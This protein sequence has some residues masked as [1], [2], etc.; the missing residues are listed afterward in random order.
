VILG[1]VVLILLGGAF[2]II[3]GS[4]NTSSP[5]PL[6]TPVGDSGIDE[7]VVMDEGSSSPS[8]AEDGAAEKTVKEFKVTGVPFSFTPNE[9]RVKK[10]DTVRVT[11]TNQEGM[12]DF[13]LDE[14]NV[15]TKT[16]SAGQSET[17][18]FVAN[19]TGKF[20]YYCSVGNHRQ[21]GM[22]GSLIVE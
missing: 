20:E 5:Q 1:I 2:M 4:S 16:L 8:A 17:V 13:V 18:E 21:M 22:V 12:H 14:F 6:L 19:N 15:R 11:F 10:G 7:A 3:R 9:M